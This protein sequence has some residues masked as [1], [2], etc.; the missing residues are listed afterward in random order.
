MKMIGP[1]QYSV[2]GVSCRGSEAAQRDGGPIR[3]SSRR[4]T[5]SRR[6]SRNI[7]CAQCL[8][9][10]AGGCTA[11]RWS[12]SGDLPAPDTDPPPNAKHHLCTVSPVVGRRLDSGPRRPTGWSGPTANA[13]YHLYTAPPSWGRGCTS[14]RRC[15]SG[16]ATAVR[17]GI[18]GLNLDFS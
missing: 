9:S 6:W 7:A 10:W 4:P 1:H 13:N 8:L 5:Q 15:D 14:R 11:R 17:P 12:D 3:G 2:H 16:V 18:Y